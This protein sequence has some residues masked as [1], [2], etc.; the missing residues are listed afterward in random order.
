MGDF[1]A[2][3]NMTKRRKPQDRWGGWEIQRGEIETKT[4]ENIML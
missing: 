1:P 4:I 3:P 2:G